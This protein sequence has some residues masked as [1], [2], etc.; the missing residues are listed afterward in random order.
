MIYQEST[1]N[2]ICGQNEWSTSSEKIKQIK[3]TNNTI[4]NRNCDMAP[5]RWLKKDSPGLYDW[6]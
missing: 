1:S 5:L 4:N 6:E 3:T 2:E